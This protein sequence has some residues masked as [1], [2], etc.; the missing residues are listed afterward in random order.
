[1]L[2]ITVLVM[3]PS[4]LAASCGGCN[5]SGISDDQVISITLSLPPNAVQL[6]VAVRL[7]LYSKTTSS[8][9]FSI[10]GTVIGISSMQI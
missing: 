7:S 8:G 5:S 6:N 2:V 1:M 4:G 9:P 3:L 10:A